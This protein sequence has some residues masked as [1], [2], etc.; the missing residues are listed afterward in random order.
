[1]A[2]WLAV[3]GAGARKEKRA[4][5]R[6]RTKHGKLSSEVHGTDHLQAEVISAYI[7]ACRE[8]GSKEVAL[9]VNERQQVSSTNSNYQICSEV[10]HASLS[11]WHR[12]L[13]YTLGSF[14]L[15]FSLLSARSVL[16]GDFLT[17]KKFTESVS[18]CLF[19]LYILIY[20]ENCGDTEKNGGT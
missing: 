20:M 17:D 2:H 7:Q 13:Q 10:L 14:L 6:P 5:L 11:M 9:T 4:A 18:G 15:M 1:M 8:L 3:E 16:L 12:L 19:A